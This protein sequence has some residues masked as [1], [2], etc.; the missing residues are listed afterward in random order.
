MHGSEDVLG[1]LDELAELDELIPEV[2]F[3][4]FLDV[5]R[6]EVRA[7]KAGDLD[8]GQQG[9]FGRRGVNVLDVNQLRHLRFRAVAMLGL[10]ERAFPP[11]PR[12]DPLLLDDE[13]ANLNA[14]GG[15]TLPLRARGRRPRAAAVRARRQRCPGAAP[16]LDAARRGGGR[17]S[18]A[19]FVVLPAALS[20]LEGRRVRVD[21]IDESRASDGFLPA[22]SA[23]ERAER[24]L[25]LDE[26]DRT[27]LERDPPLGRARARAARA[28]RLASGRASARALGRR[29]SSPRSTAAF[30]T[31]RRS[32]R[33]R[34]LSPKGVL[35][36]RR[37][38]RRTPRART[39]TSCRHV[40]R[41][42][43]LEEPERLLRMEAMTRGNVVHDV[44]QRFV[45]ELEA[46]ARSR[47][48]DALHREGLL[49]LAEEALGRARGRGPDRRAASLAR[50][51]AGDR[52]RPRSVARARARRPGPLHGPRGRGRLRRDLGDDEQNPLA[53][54][55]PFELQVG[56]RTLRLERPDR[57]DR[58]RR[59]RATA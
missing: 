21:E 55:E 12:Q 36:R 22:V 35:S 40:L 1:Y 42:R 29:A 57:P 8:E 15:W 3:A 13:R 4:R 30:P 17:P 56:S 11:P 32:P 47:E 37:I 54:E 31:A 39:G 26:R 49:S 28:A 34:R 20:A 10:T 2:G 7:L 5:V 9:A 45:A 14:A 44:L 38:S 16:A 59:A 50:R 19:A 33:S 48:R 46:P 24:A 6:A 23:R 53:S 43:P 18:A 58:L 27:L 25:T 51:P 52:R 41:A